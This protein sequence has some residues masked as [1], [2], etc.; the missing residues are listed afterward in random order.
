MSDVSLR[1]LSF[2]MTSEV[3]LPLRWKR[4]VWVSTEKFE[5][6]IEGI[7]SQTPATRPASSRLMENGADVRKWWQNQKEAKEWN[8]T[9]WMF[10]SWLECRLDT[11]IPIFRAGIRSSSS[12]EGQSRRGWGLWVVLLKRSL[13]GHLGSTSFYFINISKFWGCDPSPH[14]R[15]LNVWGCKNVF[16]VMSWQDNHA[17]RFLSPRGNASRCSTAT[18]EWTHWIWSLNVSVEGVKLQ[19]VRP[20][21][22]SV[23]TALQ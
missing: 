11:D 15:F 4:C 2:H 6:S 13:E 17:R 14:Q 8:G 23:V 18:L 5:I 10:Y 16:A 1:P 20:S 12:T 7:N 3:R 19:T 21:E 9:G 22:T